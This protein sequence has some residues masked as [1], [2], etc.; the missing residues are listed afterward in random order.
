MADPNDGKSLPMT[1]PMIIALI[2]QIV[3]VFNRESAIFF[4]NLL[5]G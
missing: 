3:Q 5:N 1:V 4:H 2:L